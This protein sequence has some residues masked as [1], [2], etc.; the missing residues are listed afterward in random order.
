MSEYMRLGAC[1]FCGQM[2]QIY[3][4]TENAGQSMIDDEA[5]EQCACTEAVRFRGMREAEQGIKMLLGEEA[6]AHGFGYALDG[7]AIEAIRTVCGCMIVGGIA[8]ANLEV[9]FGDKVSVK[10]D[11][12]RIKI[13]R[14]TKREAEV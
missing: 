12:A 4:Y 7:E 11:G 2:K 13:K 10:M 6:T 9:S 8:K 3:G 14:S 1:R 5:T